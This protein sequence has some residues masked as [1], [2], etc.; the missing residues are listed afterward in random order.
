MMNAWD[1]GALAIGVG[2]R[3]DSRLNG[4]DFGAP[5]SSAS[6]ANLIG[7]TFEKPTI[8]VRM[9]VEEEVCAAA[10]LMYQGIDDM[11]SGRGIERIRQAWEHS[12]R[13][14]AG[15]PSGEWSQGWD[16]IVVGFEIFA[17]LG[18]PERGGS[19]V[20]DLRAHVYGD[21]AYTTCL[22]TAAPAF[23]SETIACTNVLRRV[24]GVWKVIHHHADKAPKMGEAAERFARGG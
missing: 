21:V 19:T 9:T 3:T 24:N 11:A 2:T 23:G 6:T 20:R 16:E 22:F 5:E 7:E 14:T 13:V 8:G 1:D 4:W 15:H 10:M 18:R 17:S 12:E